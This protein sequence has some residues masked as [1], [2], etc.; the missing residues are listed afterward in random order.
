MAKRNLNGYS[1]WQSWPDIVL[2]QMLAVDAGL[3][4]CVHV[5]PLQ[6]W[7]CSA[8]ITNLKACIRSY[9]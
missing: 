4:D 3:A 9:R 5:R 7:Y 6:Q 1:W 2:V 8:L